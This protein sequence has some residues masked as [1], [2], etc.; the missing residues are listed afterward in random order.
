MN[1]TTILLIIGLIAAA[2]NVITT[3][4]IYDFLKS[5]DIKANFLLLRLL[6]LK[7]LSQYREIT[8]KETGKTGILY[9]HWIISINIV[10]AAV[11]LFLLL[12]IA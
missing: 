6:V 8:Q 10:L 9:Y 11:I 12:Q 5:R 4:R 2:W 7:Y 3:I 1:I